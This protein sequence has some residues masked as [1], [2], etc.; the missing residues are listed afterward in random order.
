MK[1]PVTSRAAAVKPLSL[2]RVLRRKVAVLLLA[3]ATALAISA[4]SPLPTPKDAGLVPVGSG[5]ETGTVS[6]GALGVGLSSVVPSTGSRPNTSVSQGA[7]PGPAPSGQAS[8]APPADQADA[9][10]ISYLNSIQRRSFAEHRELCGY[11]VLTPSGE[12][13]ATPPVPGDMATCSQAA[14][15][16][17]V[18]A[19]YHTHGAFDDGY[20]NE[21]P[22]PEDLLADFHFGIDGYVSTP[23]G[24]VWRAEYDVQAALLI[25]GQGCVAVDPA[26]D[27]A[28]DIGI[29][30]RY[31]VAQLQAR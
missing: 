31:T 15:G 30:N 20:D 4:C 7:G 10:A 28:D 21:V 9:F 12:I 29:R 11:F 22:S 18:F 2:V 13:A 24:R 8:F 25:C 27:F 17:D 3:L 5:R 26:Y 23:G 16:T 6:T 1:R 19:S 14:P